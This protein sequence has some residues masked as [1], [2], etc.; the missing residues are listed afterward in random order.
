MESKIRY[1]RRMIVVKRDFWESLS[2]EFVDTPCLVFVDDGN[3]KA[4][5]FRD[6]KEVKD[7]VGVEITRSAGRP[8]LVKLSIW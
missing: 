8:A 2:S 4:R 1:S 7:I 6:G 5:L 3:G